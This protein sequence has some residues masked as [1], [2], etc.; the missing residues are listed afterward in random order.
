MHDANKQVNRFHSSGAVDLLCQGEMH[1]GAAQ[2]VG[3]EMVAGCCRRA[4]SVAGG[5]KAVSPLRIITSS[6]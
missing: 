1:H 3:C 6:V 5:M 4:R 2:V